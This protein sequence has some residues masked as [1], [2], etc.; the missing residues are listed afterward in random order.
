L[1]PSDDKY[2]I[3]I[4]NM[5][6]VYPGLDLFR[7]HRLLQKFNIGDNSDELRGMIAASFK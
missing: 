7:E 2:A 4:D 5:K 3:I 6:E 1:R